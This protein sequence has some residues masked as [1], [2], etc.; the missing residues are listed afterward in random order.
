[1]R[2]W[3]VNQNQTYKHEVQGGFLWSPKRKRNGGKNHFYDTMAQVRPGDLVLSF[4]DTQIKAIGTA[5]AAAIS[6]S[7]PAFG[8]VGD[9]WSDDGWL[10]AVEFQIADHPV[11]PK[12]HM[13]ELA[14]HLAPK[15]AP[16]Q[17][18]GNGNQAVYLAEVS[19]EFAS[20]I[21]EKMGVKFPSQN[22]AEPDEI[23]VEQK[24]EAEQQALL[25]RTDIGETQKQQL[26][27]ARRG[28][29]VFKANV[30]LNEA[31]CRVTGVT[32]LRFLIASHI[33]PW[34][35]CSDEEKLDGCN[36]LLLSP[37]VDR[38]FDRGY[39]SFEGNGALL[40]SSQLSPGVWDAWGLGHIQNVGGFNARQAAYLEGHRQFIFIP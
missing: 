8:K 17:T 4:C 30:R 3:W 27:M 15:Y 18:N 24:E 21:L 7:K 19:E 39:I 33:K 12:D 28:Q 25:G 37:H 35:K 13:G 11:R 34:S 36:G 1:M 10:V 31:R 20:I 23:A 9:Q 22:G 14:P 6:S 16:L 29:G 2:Y 32:D 40:I 5:Q 38:L 26:V